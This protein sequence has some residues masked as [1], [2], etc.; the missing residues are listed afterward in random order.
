MGGRVGAIASG[1]Q[2]DG[3]CVMAFGRHDCSAWLNI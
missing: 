2:Y 1:V 3:L